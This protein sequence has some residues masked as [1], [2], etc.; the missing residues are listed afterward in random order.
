MESPA[1][2]PHVGKASKNVTFGVGGVGS[3]EGEDTCEDEQG[4]EDKKGH[5]PEA[6]FFD[7]ST[8]A[9]IDKEEIKHDAGEEAED[10]KAEA[11]GEKFAVGL[12]ADERGEVIGVGSGIHAEVHL[13]SEIFP[14]VAEAP[15]FDPEVVHVDDDG[16][17]EAENAEVGGE[18][19]FPDGAENPRAR[20]VPLLSAKAAHGPFRP[21][22]GQ[23]EK[24]ESEEVGDKEGG[25][26]I[27]GSEPR[28]AEEVA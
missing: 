20:V 9:S 12:E 28:E 15:R 27:F 14:S 3:A 25:P 6:D 21:S 23:A 8:K 16:D 4:T 1:D 5:P 19:I 22:D 2:V 26:I 13:A 11:V 18:T 24:K 7:P 10:G 17:D